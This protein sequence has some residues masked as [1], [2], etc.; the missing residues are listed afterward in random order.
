M[1]SKYILY[2]CVHLLSFSLMLHY[3]FIHNALLASVLL[4]VVV[5]FIGTYI[6]ARRLVFLSGGITHAS[7]GGIGLGW[8]LGISPIL[9]AA[10][11]AVLSA[12]GFEAITRRRTLREDS[13][14]GMLWALGMALGVF[15]VFLTPGYAPN[16]MSYLFGNI[17]TISQTDIAMLSALVAAVLLFFGLL[18]RPIL[19]VAFDSRYAMSQRPTGAMLI[20]CVLKVLVALA[21]VLSIRAVGIILLISLLTAP[22]NI[23]NLLTRRFYPMVAISATTALLSLLAGLWL[24]YSL[25]VPSGAAVVLI[26]V[27]T[28]GVIRL[29]NG[30]LR[31]IR[32]PRLRDA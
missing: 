4:A 17:L 30:I 9:G 29:T 7:F 13:A 28:Y 27:L 26:L 14:I 20:D 5:G 15:F 10:V 1:P 11:F 31:A 3:Q 16:L 8:Y 6:V 21:I 22:A 2:F 12:L 32:L 19:F 23:A 25:N 24:S 18:H